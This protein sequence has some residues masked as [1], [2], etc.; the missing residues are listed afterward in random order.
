[1]A[2][3][4]ARHIAEPTERQAQ[5]AVMQLVEHG[6]PGDDTTAFRRCLGQF[7]TGVAVIT[8]QDSGELIG[9]TSNSFASVSLQPPL[10]LWSMR[11]SSTSYSAFERCE[12]F[13]VNILAS[14]QVAL[15]QKFAKSGPDKFAGVE[16]V[17]GINGVPLLNGVVARFECR[18]IQ[19][20]DGGDHLIMIG[21][22]Q[23]FSRHKGRE[24]LLF[25]QGRYATSL[26]HP[27]AVSSMESN[28]NSG[29][30]SEMEPLSSLLARAHATIEPALSTARQI[31]NL[32][33]MEA[34][35]L[36]GVLSFP[37]HSLSE[38]LPKLLLGVGAAED[39]LNKLLERNLIQLNSR[40]GLTATPE[41]DAAFVKLLSHARR[42]ESEQLVGLSSQ[43][44]ESTRRVLL[45]LVSRNQHT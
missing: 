35:L 31:Q 3:S 36:R 44:I 24:A 2:D 20:H 15:S 45:E 29:I 21:E 30:F 22:V 41:G 6:S 1:M 26:D 40:G 39:V 25:V 7:G 13:A 18:S 11:R 10:I 28:R 12:Y 5:D 19:N 23:R 9:M 4:K 17:S 16:W 33:L 42:L 43:D 8:T 32:S 38:L 27:E 14:D 34:R 37:G